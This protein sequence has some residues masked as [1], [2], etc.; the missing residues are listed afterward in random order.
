MFD[1]QTE[2]QV[3]IKTDGLNPIMEWDIVE[4]LRGQAHV[5]VQATASRVPSLL[6][7]AH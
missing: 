7:F 3:L 6:F 2:H 1:R 5:N 4:F